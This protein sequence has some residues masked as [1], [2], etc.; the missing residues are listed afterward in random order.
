MSKSILSKILA[1][2]GI[3]FFLVPWIAY[4][5]KAPLT[6]QIND[7]YIEKGQLEVINKNYKEDIDWLLNYG[8]FKNIF[9]STTNDINKSLNSLE[10]SDLIRRGR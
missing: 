2:F 6:S 8:E 4:A 5:L 10:T 3:V 7:S 1:V 9:N